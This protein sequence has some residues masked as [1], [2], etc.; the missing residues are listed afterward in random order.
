MLYHILMDIEDFLMLKA[1]FVNKLD[2]RQLE[3]YWGYVDEKE[4]V[5]R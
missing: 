4:S 3:R 2:Q 1:D 5:H